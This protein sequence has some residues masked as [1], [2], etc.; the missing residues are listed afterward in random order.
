MNRNSALIWHPKVESVYRTPKTIFVP[1]NHGACVSLME[2]EDGDPAPWN[3]AVT[4]ISEAAEKIGYPVFIRTDLSSAKHAGPKAYKADSMD[5]VVG[6]FARTVEDSE[7]KFWTAQPPEA[8]M[9]RQFLELHH[10]FTAFRGL[11][12]AREFRFFA[13]GK[14]VLC[15]HPYWP[16][17]AL[18][19]HCDAEGWQDKLV[20]LCLT[21]SNYSELWCAAI[22]AADACGGDAWS[23][24]FAM[25]RD[26]GWY[27]IDMARMEDSWH[28][29]GCPNGEKKVFA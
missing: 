24:D 22:V 8:I 23:V 21:P 13:N 5:D 9:V 15:S 18:E 1:Y 27:L 12:I 25:D 16:A 6:V 7:M 10:T 17:D 26:G 28:W 19:D 20:D 4:A 11:P 29:P 2:M 3:D 14:R